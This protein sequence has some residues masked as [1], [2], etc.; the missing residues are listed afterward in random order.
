[1]IKK[2]IQILTLVACFGFGM[3]SAQAS[4][5]TVNAGDSALWNFDLTGTTPPPP[6]DIV[7][8]F[9][10]ITTTYV[11]GTYSLFSDLDGA[12]TL[13]GTAPSS[14]FAII[15]GNPG[16]LDGLFSLQ[17][18]LDA[19]TGSMSLEP[20]A[21]GTASDVNTANVYGVVVDAAV[22]EP[23]TLALF[24]LGLA[25]LGFARKKKKSA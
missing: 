6:F 4:L 23:A 16:W 15:G 24:G 19:G 17:L 12:G 25:G 3:S 22:P 1:M 5:I 11:P 20:Y 18:A 8:L 7:S 14:L 2:I 10:G 13:I 9:T 21:F